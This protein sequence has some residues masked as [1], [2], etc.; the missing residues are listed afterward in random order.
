M[1]KKEIATAS[2][3]ILLF[4]VIALLTAGHLMGIT[5]A[6]FENSFFEATGI[7]TTGGLSANA[8]TV[9]LDPATKI[10]FAASS[11]DIWKT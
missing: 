2:L 11:Y 8:I 4:P 6:S 7:I 10:V 1:R 9:D 3:V 5:D